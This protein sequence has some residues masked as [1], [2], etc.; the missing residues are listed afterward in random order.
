MRHF[1]KATLA[2]ATLAATAML[3]AAPASAVVVTFASFSPIGS[4][5]NV[6]WV[7]S[8]SNASFYSTATNNAVV[9][10]ARNVNFSLL[11]PSINPF[12]NNVTARFSLNGV[13]TNTVA[14]ISGSTITQRNING[15][16]SFLTTA[17]ILIG[18]NVFAT[19]SNLLS[20]TF[21]QG[22]I[23]GT[24]NTTAGGFTGSTPVSTIT[25]TSDFLAF[26]PGSDYDFAWGLSSILPMLNAL[27]VASVPL[28]ALRSF[29]AVAGGNFSSDPAPVVTAIPEPGVWGMMIVG[30]G[31]VGFAARRRK[32]SVA[33]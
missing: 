14:T 27:P 8:L 5:A 10:G 31:M 19:G 21:T 20:G 24:R 1:V 7:S 30:F 17:P 6:R 3:G 25:Y 29:R 16:F 4:G 12:V 28:R 26:I 32:I 18:T 15:S 13:V 23:S 11:Q 2:A 22:A 9:P 33:A